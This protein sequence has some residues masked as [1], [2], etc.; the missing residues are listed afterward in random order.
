[1]PIVQSPVEARDTFA[2]NRVAPR[3]QYLHT[4]IVSTLATVE[5]ASQVLEE[6][7]QTEQQTNQQVED[8]DEDTDSGDSWNPYAGE[9]A[10][11]VYSEG[12]LSEVLAYNIQFSVTRLTSSWVNYLW[13][14]IPL[15]LM[16][17]GFFIGRRRIMERIHDHIPLLRKAFWLGLVFGIAGTWFGEVLFG[18]AA[19]AGWDPWVWFAGSVLWVLAGWGMALGYAAGIVLLGQRDFWQTCLGPLQA[20]GRLA[21]TNYLLQ[22]LI[23]TTLFYSYGLGLYGKVG[24]ADA[25]LLAIAIY[26]LQVALSSLWVRRFRFGPAEWLWR[27]IT[28][29]RLQPMRIT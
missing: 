20:I 21:L 11:R 25:T 14:S 23:C 12:D 28:Y 13:M 17:T 2:K 5:T 15:P 27:S 22:T 16:L 18:W 1:M 6:A 7:E 19:M 3:A 26:V 8:E 9:R 10:V 29:G 24:P 4:A